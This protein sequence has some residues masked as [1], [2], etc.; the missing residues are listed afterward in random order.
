MSHE[1]THHHC[2]TAG[3]PTGEKM[4]CIYTGSVMNYA[5]AVSA[6]GMREY[7]IPEY[8]IADFQKLVWDQRMQLIEKLYHMGIPYTLHVPH[9]ENFPD[10]E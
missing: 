10:H 8:A 1:D 2:G 7:G 3:K 5:V 6:E 4:I 9:A